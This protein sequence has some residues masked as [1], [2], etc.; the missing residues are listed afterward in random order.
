MVDESGR[1]P[2]TQADLAET[3]AIPVES[4]QVTE[5]LPAWSDGD[6]RALDALIPVVYNELRRQ[7]QRYLR[8]ERTGH[9]L[10]ARGRAI[11]CRSRRARRG[12]VHLTGY[13]K[14]G[15]DDGARLAQA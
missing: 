11:G 4:G 14:A 9:S 15:L 8:R 12:A 7:A 6:E 13:R 5:L 3:P 2:P 1:A 10:Q